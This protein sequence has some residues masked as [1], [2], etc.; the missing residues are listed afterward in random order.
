MYHVQERRKDTRP[1]LASG[2]PSR[3]YRHTDNKRVRDWVNAVNCQ[4]R[5]DR[6]FRP[7]ALRPAGSGLTNTPLSG[8]LLASPVKD[9]GQGESFG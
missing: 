4:S 7:D 8:D 5:R 9:C 6:T 3:L 1:G 2:V